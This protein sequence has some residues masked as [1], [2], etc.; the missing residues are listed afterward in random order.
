MAEVVVPALIGGAVNALVGSI[1]SPPPPR[2]QLP[3]VPEIPVLSREE[4]LQLAQST[5][6]PL[7][8]KQLQ[9]TLRRVDIDNIRRGFFGQVPGAALS[10]A[11]AADV[12]SARAASIANLAEQMVGQSQQAALQAAALA[13]QGVLQQHQLALQQWQNQAN[14]LM[15][16]I[17][18]GLL[19]A[20]MWSD[21][22]GLVPFSGG[23]WTLGSRQ[24]LSN[25]GVPQ[26]L[27]SPPTS[28]A[29][30]GSN[31]NWINPY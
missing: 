27:S 6:N 14:N 21:W 3:Q 25:I 23:L 1:F 10:G 11:R 18:T 20:Q 19:G 26:A 17:Q 15:R 9:E 22:T 2:L 12:E 4:A 5:L 28:G 31:P 24:A 29:F 13:Q 16:G 30:S 7:F 8:D